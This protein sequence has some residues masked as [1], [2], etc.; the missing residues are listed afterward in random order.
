MKSRRKALKVYMMV[1]MPAPFS[2][3]YNVTGTIIETLLQQVSK[4]RVMWEI[5]IFEALVDY[6]DEKFIIMGS[7]SGNSTTENECH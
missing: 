2:Y 3:Q 5:F 1:S 7:A 6:F 4:S